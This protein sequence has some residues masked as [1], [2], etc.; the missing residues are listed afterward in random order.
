ML[1]GIHGGLLEVDDQPVDFVDDQ[2]GLHAFLKGLLDDRERLRAHSFDCVDHHKTAITKTHL[3]GHVQ[4]KST[5][6]ETSEL[7]SM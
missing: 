3:D 6:A 1:V 7:K 4:Q 2:N 5:A